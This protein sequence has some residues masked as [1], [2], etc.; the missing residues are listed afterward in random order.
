MRAFVDQQD[1]EALSVQVEVATLGNRSVVQE[2]AYAG[3]SVRWP[4]TM[5]LEPSV[6]G[7]YAGVTFLLTMLDNIIAQSLV[8]GNARSYETFPLA[9]RGV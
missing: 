9:H 4:E 7:V 8:T 6:K 3:D 1:S 5:D 2:A